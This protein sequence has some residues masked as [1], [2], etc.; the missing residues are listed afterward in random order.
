MQNAWLRDLE[1]VWSL[2]KKAEVRKSLETVPA[3]ID[4]TPKKKLSKKKKAKSGKT[5][6]ESNELTLDGDYCNNDHRE[7]KSKSANF[8]NIEKFS[9]PE[10]NRHSPLSGV[11]SEAGIQFRKQGVGAP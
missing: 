5:L 6:N 4:T 3:K 11:T 8:A 7:E 10:S 2:K 1:L 9:S